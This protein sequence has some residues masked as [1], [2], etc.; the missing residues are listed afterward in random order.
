MVT[1]ST[2]TAVLEQPKAVAHDMTVEELYAAI[3]Q[4]VKAIYQE[5]DL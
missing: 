4:E 2:D 5:D 3:K 1:I